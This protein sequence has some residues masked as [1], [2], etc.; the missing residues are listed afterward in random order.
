MRSASTALTH[1]LTTLLLCCGLAVA[2]PAELAPYSTVYSPTRDPFADAAAAIELAQTSN[3]R[4]LIE[5]GGDWCSWCH[6]LDRLI[7]TDTRLYHAL[8]DHFVLLKVNVSDT[9]ANANFMASMPAVDGYPQLF[10]ARANG[11][12][13]HIQDP[14]EF[15]ADGHYVAARVLAFLQRWRTTDGDWQ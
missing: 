2:G 10:V 9:N 7:A 1:L 12:I 15:S 5:V 14:A 6:I 4:I 3:R 8:H 13:I 11:N